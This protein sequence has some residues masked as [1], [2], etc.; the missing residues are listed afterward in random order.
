MQ[1]RLD[2]LGGF[3][4]APMMAAP[5]MTSQMMSA[6]AMAAPMMAAPKVKL[7]YQS[8]ISSQ[9]SNGFWTSSST[10]TIL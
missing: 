6:P 2:Q 1:A 8:L 9:D 5:A 4:S 7:S 3:S 10:S